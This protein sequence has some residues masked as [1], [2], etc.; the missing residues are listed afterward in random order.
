M[1]KLRELT[2]ANF[3]DAI[4]HELKGERR[5]SGPTF[6]DLPLQVDHLSVVHVG[7]A[8]HINLCA[9]FAC[10]S[11]QDIPKDSGEKNE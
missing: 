11:K 9:L 4:N 1:Y 3:S 10:C 5:P 7:N 8:V 6:H 2:L